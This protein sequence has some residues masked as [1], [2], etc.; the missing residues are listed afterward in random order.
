MFRREL[1]KIL[2]VPLSTLRLNG[3]S[4][5]HLSYSSVTPMNTESLTRMFL[6]PIAWEAAEMKEISLNIDFMIDVYAWESLFFS[7]CLASHNWYHNA[8]LIVSH[9]SS[10]WTITR[11]ERKVGIS[12]RCGRQLFLVGRGGCQ[13]TI[14][15]NFLKNCMKLKEF[16][17]GGA[18]VPRAPLR[19]ANST[20]IYI[21]NFNG[22]FNVHYDSEVTCKQIPK[23]CIRVGHRHCQSLSLCEWCRT[24]WWTDWVRNPFCRAMLI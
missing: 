5:G 6:L 15:V 14:S 4:A 23:T 18:H 19:S 8:F 11:N 22:D 2:K 10:S 3:S 12:P 24:I 20:Q 13:H 21:L 1:W 17:Q 7:A 9:W 16:G